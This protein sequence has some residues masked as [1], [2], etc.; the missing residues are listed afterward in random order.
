MRKS[1]AILVMLGVVLIGGLGVQ[2]VLAKDTVQMGVYSIAPPFSPINVAMEKMNEYI[3]EKSGG[4][5]EI[6]LFPSGQ[7][8]AES[9]G[10]N[11]LRIGA[12]QAGSITGVAIST[13]E[14]KAN[15]LML[16]FVIKDWDDV[17]KLANSS[18]MDE[19]GTSLDAKG[20]K[21]MGIG[22]YG[23]FNILA[24]K[25][26]LVEPA[27]FPGVK[28]RVFPTPVLVDLYKALGAS[29]TPISFPEIY[30]ALQQ[31]VIEA[32][33]GTLD[34]SHA[35]KQYEVAKHLTKTEHI[36]GWFLY[37]VN[38]PWFESLSKEH[39]ELLQDAFKKYSAVA[40]EE[41]KKYDEKVLKIYEE[42]GVEIVSLTPEQREALKKLTSPI[43]EKYRDTIGAEFLDKFYKE[44][45]FQK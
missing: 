30:T 3:K 20:L 8:G 35:S 33:D 7:L 34:S 13:I 41:S 5:L 4:T 27:D 18:I 12:V 24:V 36:H 25:K 37:L 22:S 10:L 11:K 29:P 16:P 2:N 44:M 23:F 26:P 14:P 19:I 6:Q 42:A 15:I 28:I 1:I 17:E 40:R 21:L 32:T 43:H 31:G 38:K 9:A 39:Q 45:N